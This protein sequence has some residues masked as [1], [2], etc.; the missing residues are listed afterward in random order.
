MAT[1]PPEKSVDYSKLLRKNYFTEAED[2]GETGKLVCN[3]CI[4]NSIIQQAPGT[5]YSGI[6]RHC[7]AKHSDHRQVHT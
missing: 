6:R 2:F 4:D 7:D 1:F 3:V 5:G